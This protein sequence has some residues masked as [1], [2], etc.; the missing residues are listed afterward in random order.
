MLMNVNAVL[1]ESRLALTNLSDQPMK[2][3]GLQAGLIRLGRK[4][5]RRRGGGGLWLRLQPLGLEG[6]KGGGRDRWGGERAGT[7]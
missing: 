7:R 5:G 6:D 3:R 2:Q 4:E 1:R